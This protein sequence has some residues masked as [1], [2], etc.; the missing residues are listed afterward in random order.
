MV[1]HQSIPDSNSK[2]LQ[3]MEGV[4]ERCSCWSNDG[5]RRDLSLLPLLFQF[6]L[7]KDNIFRPLFEAT[8][9]P[10]KHRSVVRL[11]SQCTGFDCVDDESRA[12]SEMPMQGD[13]KKWDNDSNPPYGYWLYYLYANIVSLNKLRAS[14]GFH[15]FSFRPHCGESG[16]VFHLADGFL[17]ATNINHGIVLGA[18]TPLQYLYYL[19][20]I[21]RRNTICLFVCLFFFFF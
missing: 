9:N 16:S 10:S 13:P 19:A 21:V 1:G 20:Q 15:C 12:D 8:L 2:T 5:N 11:L 7:E 17:C 6:L 14:R 4:Q 3:C 18:N